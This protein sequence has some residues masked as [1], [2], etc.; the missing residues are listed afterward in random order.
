MM[1]VDGLHLF[2]QFGHSF[3]QE[4]KGLQQKLFMWVPNKTVMLFLTATCTPRIKGYFQKQIG[5]KIMDTYC[6][7]PKQMSDCKVVID[8]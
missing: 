4:F 3:H 6:L 7:S 1:V 2:T 8:V 5:L